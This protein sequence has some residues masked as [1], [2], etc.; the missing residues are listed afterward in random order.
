MHNMNGLVPWL[1]PKV[2]DGLTDSEIWIDY[3]ADNDIN[4][5][6]RSESS[7]KRQARKVREVL[8]KAEL[9][10]QDD[11]DRAT[12]LLS[13]DDKENEL[14]IAI[15]SYDIK[16]INGLRDWANIDD[17]EWTCDR[18]KVRASQNLKTPWFIVEGFFKRREPGK[19]SIQEL[20]ENAEKIITKYTPKKIP[21]PKLKKGKYL[22]EISLPDL[23][24]GNMN[25]NDTETLETTS[26]RFKNAVAYF[27]EETKHKELDEIIITFGSDFFTINADKPETK[28]GTFQDINAYYND[29][30]ETGL[31]VAIDT[32]YY[33]RSHA[34]KLKVIGF[35][36]NHDEQA[37]VW[38][39]L[40]LNQMFKNVDGVEVDYKYAMRKYYR[41]G[42]T[43]LTFV[44]K[45]SKKLEK[46][47]LIM[48][49][50]MIDQ[51]LIDSGVKYYEIHGG[52]THIPNKQE[53][54]AE[55][56]N[57]KITQRV[58]SSL[59]DNSRW[60]HDNFGQ[61]V[62]EGQAFLYD[63]GKGVK[64]CLIFRPE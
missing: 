38:L 22:L 14:E 51:G 20:T 27:I 9:L 19:L 8:V 37:T 24:L 13:R 50:E 40:C 48:F 52:D 33:L 15:R 31:Q 53:M 18:Q 61:K 21:V 16:D 12:R 1:I 10:I 2:K 36:G 59:T 11:L 57:Q 55:S 34:R 26:T 56:T 30:Y 28:K 7:V 6:S 58:L 42:C 35:P 64:N 3:L 60:A 43:A 54:P 44:H 39:M 49:Q 63:Y 32:I 29:I 4:N 23:H 62:I 5:S 46:L 17:K 45:L 25:F 47:P 41:F